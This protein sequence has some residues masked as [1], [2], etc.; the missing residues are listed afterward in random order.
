M[1]RYERA[2]EEQ[3]VYGLK[4]YIEDTIGDK[5]QEKRRGE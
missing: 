2:I 3:K 1:D 5:K 4:N